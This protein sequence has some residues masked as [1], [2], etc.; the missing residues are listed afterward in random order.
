LAVILQL[1]EPMPVETPLG[2]GYAVLVEGGAHDYWWTVALDN[3]AL[4]SFSQDRIRMQKSYSHRRGLT[5]AQMRAVV[6]RP[7]QT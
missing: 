7:R 6:R 4:V 1:P 5:D 2:R 3:G